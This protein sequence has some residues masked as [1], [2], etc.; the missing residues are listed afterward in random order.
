MLNSIEMTTQEA[1]QYILRLSMCKSSRTVEYKNTV[2]P[3]ERQKI[4]KQIKN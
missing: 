4:K 1:V 3:Q 2:W